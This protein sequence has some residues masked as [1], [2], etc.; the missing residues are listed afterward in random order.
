VLSS[1]AARGTTPTLAAPEHRKVDEQLARDLSAL[2]GSDAVSRAEWGV[3]F[4]SLQHGQPLYTLNPSKLLIPASSQKLLSAAVAAEKLGWDYRYTTRI[5]STAAVGSDGI[6]DGDLL[7]VGSGDPTINP[8]H[9]DRWRAPDDW[10]AAL[11]AK[12]IRIVSG[13]LIGDDNAFAEPGWGFGW[14]WDDLFYGYGAE[15]TALQYNENK[16]E[17]MVGPGME[18]GSRAI[19]STSPYGH[20]LVIDHDVTTAPAGERTSVE[21]GRRPGT[22]F[23]TVRGR[24]AADAAPVTIDASADNPTRFFVT[25]FREALARNGI[26]VAGGVLDVDELRT[27]IAHDG[28]LELLVDRSPPLS[29]IIDVA[30]KWSR[31]IYAETLL[32]SVAPPPD[33]ASAPRA[34]DVLRETL[35]S[36]GVPPETYVA[37]DGSGLSRYDYVSADAIVALLKSLAAQPRHA[38]PFESS[39]PVSGLSGTLANRMKGT[40]AE[41]RVHAKTGTM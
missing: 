5:L 7:I 19:I 13:R 14:S 10:A 26:Y 25:A 27:P 15:P 1:C 6:V 12:G 2:F 33:P 18:P 40:P 21:I 20:G 9:P 39:L 28:L 34:L 30:L 22:P 3:S 16:I 4:Q 32:L 23:L 11:R 36:W 35:R 17:V 38:A 29:E 24:I 37:R 8:R 41:G 31:N